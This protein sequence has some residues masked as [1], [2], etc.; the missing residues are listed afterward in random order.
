MMDEEEVRDLESPSERHHISL[1]QELSS[2][3]N[4]LDVAIVGM[5]PAGLYTAWRLS[6][7]SPDQEIAGIHRPAKSLRVALFDTMSEDRVGGRL[8]TQP[9]PGYPFLAELGGMRYR[10]GQHLVEGLI[11]ALGMSGQ[12]KP[13]KFDNQFYFLRGKHLRK[14]QFS[15]DNNEFP[16]A[17]EDE[18]KGQQPG[19]L[20]EYAIQQTLKSLRCGRDWL[21]SREGDEWGIKYEKLR[22]KL[23]HLEFLHK[24]SPREWAL[25]KRFG[26]YRGGTELSDVGFWDLLQV[27]LSAEAWHLAHD[28]LGY[29]SI[30]GNWNASI[31]LP[32]FVNDFST[33]DF[34]TL[35]NGM[36]SIPQ[37]LYDQIKKTPNYNRRHEWDL[38][39]IELHNAPNTSAQLIKLEFNTKL[40][41]EK[42]PVFARSVVLALPKGALIRLDIK[43]SL[44]ERAAPPESKLI[45]RSWFQDLL[46][47]VDGRPLFKLFLGYSSPWWEEKTSFITGKGNTDLPLRQVYYY[48]KD[49]WNEKRAKELGLSLDKDHYSMLMASY[50]DSHY[51]EFWSERD[52]P[53][54]R[55][56]FGREGGIKVLPKDDET[57]DRY[58]L[59]KF[60]APRS[61]IIRA[62]H[63]LKLLHGLDK[64]SES[65]ITPL[66]EV[67]LYMEWS[68]APYYAGWHSWK[69]GVKPWE[70][71][72]EIMQPFKNTQVFICGEAYS[73]EQGW[74]EGALKSAERLLTLK[75]K[76]PLLPQILQ[77]KFNDDINELKDYIDAIDEGD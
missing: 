65:D 16:Y 69:V 5:G 6:K 72:R 26:E 77:D 23:G 25:L 68:R 45:K 59:E 27:H 30:M 56:Y 3:E 42:Q 1:S 38:T 18:E 61:M 55:A 71:C 31:A 47:S 17:L 29:E 8:C 76:L 13:F 49:Q 70:V 7:A 60:G 50:S 74:T 57:R 51:I 10:K 40:E 75:F 32:W 22:E 21:G 73:D 54:G 20:I 64:L 46:H 34:F 58:A 44:I 11:C 52:K 12:I 43:D 24:L 62:E 41:K 37:T 48:G 39:G 35:E 53:K 36:S 4:P 66:A 14:A 63:Q 2:P 15:K 33:N 19:Q 28:G 67:G 9:L